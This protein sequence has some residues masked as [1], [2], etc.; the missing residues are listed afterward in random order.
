MI[1]IRTAAANNEKQ[2]SRKVTEL[3]ILVWVVSLL[4]NF[5][6]LYVIIF[7]IWVI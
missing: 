3:N 4:F 2:M 6:S 7:F 1:R 5:L